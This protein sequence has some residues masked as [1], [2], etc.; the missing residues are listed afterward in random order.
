[1]HCEPKAPAQNQNI[2]YK[3]HGESDS[4]GRNKL[5]RS[6]FEIFQEDL[7]LSGHYRDHLKCKNLW[8]L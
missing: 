8:D 6:K 4:T 2:H 5:P 7:I 3:Y 1:M